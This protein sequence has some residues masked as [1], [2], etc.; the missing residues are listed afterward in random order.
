MLSIDDAAIDQKIRQ[1]NVTK[2]DFRQATDRRNA[3]ERVLR[4]HYEHLHT[5]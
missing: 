5:A 1:I 2:A 3:F 4:D